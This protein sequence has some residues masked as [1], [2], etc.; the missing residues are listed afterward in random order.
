M[1]AKGHR[2]PALA[3][4]HSRTGS[5]TKLPLNHLQFTQKKPLAPRP[6]QQTKQRAGFHIASPGED[7]DEEDWVSSESG[8]ATPNHNNN[9]DNDEEDSDLES[10]PDDKPDL[11]RVP[12]AR[13][14]DYYTPLRVDT[15]P[16]ARPPNPKRHSSRP[17]SSHSMF[18]KP[19]LR[20]HPL[21]RGQSFGQPLTAKPSPLLPV[22]VT[23]QTD[24]IGGKLSTSP[25]IYSSP[26]TSP[27]ARR[28]SISSTRSAAT[29][30]VL[31]P[32]AQPP[33]TRT[34]STASSSAA[35]SS[36][37]HLPTHS[38][39]PTPQMI[40]FFPPANPHVHVDAIHPLLPPPYIHNHL[41]VLARRTPIRES[42]DRVLKARQAR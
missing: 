22:A 35:F 34:L 28:T 42:F 19:E 39:P 38:R 11:Q 32:R 36:L 15:T 4:A 2:A 20:P 26:P 14:S 33:R 17:T 7:E 41:T 21:I 37:T 40:A 16:P 6:T 8:A 3:R 30:A 24:I 31:P 18:N 10:P 9:D 29:V 1:P 23:P 27:L 5:A 12:T 13:M 25:T